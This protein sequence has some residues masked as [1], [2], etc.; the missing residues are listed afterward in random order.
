MELWVRSQFALYCNLSIA[1]LLMQNKSQAVKVFI[2]ML[3]K[4]AGFI[5]AS[6]SC[7]L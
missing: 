4:L 1:K 6:E 2:Y 5:S 7:K 3:L